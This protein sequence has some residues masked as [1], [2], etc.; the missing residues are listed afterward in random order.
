MA[1]AGC[2]GGLAALTAGWASTILPGGLIAAGAVLTVLGAVAA[3]RD[4]LEWAVIPTRVAG[5][6][7][8]AMGLLGLLTGA[9]LASSPAA[10]DDATSVPTPTPVS[11]DSSTAADQLNAADHD[12]APGSQPSGTSQASPVTPT[13]TAPPSKASTPSAGVVA[14]SE[15]RVYYANCAAVRAAGAAPIYPSEP[16]WQQKFDRDRDGVGC[17]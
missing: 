12:A 6:V 1:A 4:G 5:C 7:I 10:P 14:G 16:G 17:E 2:L 13:S 15:P 8:A 3:L 9:V 11:A